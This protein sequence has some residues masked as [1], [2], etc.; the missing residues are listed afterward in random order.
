[1]VFTG[2]SSLG[3]LFNDKPETETWTEGESKTY[4][5]PNE[6]GG[7]ISDEL[8]GHTFLFP[9]GGGGSFTLTRILS[10]PQTTPDDSVFSITYSGSGSVKLIV[11]AKPGEI[12]CIGNAPLAGSGI[13]VDEA[14]KDCQSVWMPIPENDNGNHTT[15]FLLPLSS[16]LKSTSWAG[17]K[18]Y[19]TIRY[20][21]IKD[22][23]VKFN[24]MVNDVANVMVN[25]M[26]SD[27]KTALEKN[28]KENQLPSIYVNNDVSIPCYKPFW[29]Y[30]G[31]A[32]RKLFMFKT[33]SQKNNVAHEFGHY[34]HHFLTDSYYTKFA[35]NPRGEGHAIGESGARNNIIEEPAYLTEYYCI[36][37]IAN[38]WD[39]TQGDFCLEAKESGGKNN[40]NSDDFLDI[41]GFGIMLMSSLIRT[42]T[43]IIDYKGRNVEVPVMN[44]EKSDRTKFFKDMYSIFESGE[45]CMDGIVTNIVDFARYNYGGAN[46]VKKLSAMWQPLGMNH[47]ATCTFVD[48]DKNPISGVTA[49]PYIKLADGKEYKLVEN[50]NASKSDGSYIISENYPGISSLRITYTTKSGEKKT[51]ELEDYINID[52]TLATNEVVELGEIVLEDQN[53]IAHLNKTIVAGVQFE[54]MFSTTKGDYPLKEIIDNNSCGEKVSWSGQ[55]FSVIK[56]YATTDGPYNSYIKSINITGSVS[57]N[58]LTVENCTATYEEK[59]YEGGTNLLRT[60]KTTIACNSI[61]FVSISSDNKKIGYGLAGNKVEG[62]ASM[63]YSEVWYDNSGITTTGIKWNDYSVNPSIVILFAAP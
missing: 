4:T 53:L 21:D 16:G 63:T 7:T 60:I 55:G 6:K 36:G 17:I 56:E 5:A 58:G 18:N 3:D 50:K 48:K 31:F 29:D 2:C 26:P 37:L 45:D 47:V 54:A 35:N 23:D 49:Q 61:P 51:L 41:E 42:H 62:K 46:S 43:S 14:D 30:F 22:L 52:W 25:V 32:T 10:G 19:K 9:E 27:Y 20:F 13:L 1:M 57:K 11:Q 24:K 39:P 59:W 28:I 44:P 33:S 34:L 8:T 15:S 38:A 12:L 40:T